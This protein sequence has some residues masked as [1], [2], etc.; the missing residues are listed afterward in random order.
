M[1]QILLVDDHP[2]V[3]EGTKALLQNVE[4]FEIGVAYDSTNALQL[5]NENN[6]DVF[7]VDINMQPVNGI[8]LA[9][10]IKN[11]CP[12]ARIILY[13]GYDL[14][15]YYDL[16]LSK[17]IDG[18]LSKAVMKDQVIHTIRGVLRDDLVISNDFVDYINQ[19]FK[20]STINSQTALTEKEL[21][22]LEL[23]AKGYTNKAIAIEQSLTQR[24]VENYLTKIFARLNVESRAEAVAMAKDKG[25]IE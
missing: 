21:A 13:T 23:V 19:K 5:M 11:L 9:K 16:I 10:M 12:N 8:E 6:F 20:H 4:D 22:I 18:L 24:T 1:I 25:F 2:V 15:D 3:L 17:E 14:Q 7:L